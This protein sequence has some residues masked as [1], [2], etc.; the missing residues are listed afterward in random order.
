MENYSITGEES[1]M[2]KQIIYCVN[3]CQHMVF[4]H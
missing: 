2:I 3:D 1:S 4:P